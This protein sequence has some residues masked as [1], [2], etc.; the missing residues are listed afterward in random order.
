MSLSNLTKSN[1]NSKS[2]SNLIES[3]SNP[4]YQNL[5]TNL[6]SCISIYLPIYLSFCLSCFL[7]FFLSVDIYIY[8][9][10]FQTPEADP[11]WAG[12]SCGRCG[13]L[14]W[15]KL[16]YI[17]LYY[18]ICFSLWYPFILYHVFGRFFVLYYICLYN[19]CS[20]LY[21]F[22]AFYIVHVFESW[23]YC[24]KNMLNIFWILCI[25][26][27]CVCVYIYIHIMLY[28]HLFPMQRAIVFLGWTLVKASK[29]GSA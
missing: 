9:P 21:H 7:S 24:V 27:V 10:I 23:M 12:W 26:I 2:K 17:K 22:L 15:F 8:I 16:Y 6:S 18:V 13:R 4:T 11:L 25:T 3:K 19:D 28:Y 1:S 20:I 29:C 5:P 14:G